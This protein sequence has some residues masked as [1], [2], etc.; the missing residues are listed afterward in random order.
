MLKPGFQGYILLLVCLEPFL[1][2]LAQELDCGTSLFL[3]LNLKPK[4]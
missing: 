4:L 1:L 2:K 3:D